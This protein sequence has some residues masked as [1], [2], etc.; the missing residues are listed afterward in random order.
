MDDYKR[1]YK[2]LKEKLKRREKS[3][4]NGGGSSRWRCTMV[5]TP[6]TSLWEL[7]G[8]SQRCFRL[9]VA[10]GWQLVG[11]EKYGDERE[12]ILRDLGKSQRGILHWFSKQIQN[13][14]W[15][16]FFLKAWPAWS[17]ATEKM[18]VTSRKCVFYGFLRTQ[19]NTRKY[20][21][22]HFL[23]CNQTHENIFLSG[24][25]HFRKIEYFPEILLHKPNGALITMLGFCK[26]DVRSELC[27]TVRG[28]WRFH[29]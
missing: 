26:F 9:L 14:I 24:K 28:F 23:K 17:L 4:P 25:W 12:E 8:G 6:Q 13:S 1:K 16:F 7:V 22:K 11:E 3:L 15:I 29:S 19:P 10:Y 20:F 2:I 21:L 18:W 27:K 5:V